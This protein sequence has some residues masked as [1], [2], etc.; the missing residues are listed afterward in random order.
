MS[1]G[2]RSGG[3]PAGVGRV[4]VSAGARAMIAVLVLVVSAPALVRAARERMKG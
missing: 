4:A 1:Q 3:G 2:N